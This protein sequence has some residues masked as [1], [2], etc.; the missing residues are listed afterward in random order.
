MSFYILDLFN[1]TTNE[2]NFFLK[3]SLFRNDLTKDTIDTLEKYNYVLWAMSRGAKT[4]LP[5]FV[6][7]AIPRRLWDDVTSLRCVK[8]LGDAMK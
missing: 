5:S 1:F 2:K 8:K 6:A 4:I 3:S 7:K